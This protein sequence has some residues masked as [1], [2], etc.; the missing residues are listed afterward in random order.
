MF[1][2][3]LDNQLVSD[4]LNWADF[5]ETVE[6]DERLKLLWIKY[7]VKLTFDREGYNYIR[8]AYLNDGFCKLVELRVEYNCSGT[9]ENVLN[10]YIF[11]SDCKFN[12]TRCTVECDVFD[13]SYG[14]KI[15]NNKSL[16]TVISAPF[17][18]NGVSI[19]PAGKVDVQLFTPSTG[20]H[21]GAT[22]NVYVLHDVFRYLIDFM[23]DDTVN[24]ESDFLSNFVINGSIMGLA[25][26]KE[27]RLA[28]GTAPTISF[29]EL[30]E[31]LN[32]VYPIGMTVVFRNNIPTIKIERDDYFYGDTISIHVGNVQDLEQAFDNELLYSAVKLG[33]ETE[34][35]N[36]KNSQS[37]IPFLTFQEEEYIIQGN[38]NIDKVL[39]LSKKVF[40]DT[41]KIEEIFV[42]ATS[43]EKFDEKN[44][45][46]HHDSSMASPP[47]YLA[48][49]FASITTGAAPYF[50]NGNITN[51]KVAS[52]YNLAGS[53]A[54]YLGANN[55]GFQASKTDGTQVG[56]NVNDPAF[57]YPP[58][59]TTTDQKIGFNNDSTPPNYDAAGNYNTTTH[60][61]TA[62]VAGD[63]NFRTNL[64]IDVN[65]GFTAFANYRFR[66]VQEFRRFN[67]SNVLQQI[68][69]NNFPS[70]TTFFN[71]GPGIYQVEGDGLT[72]MNVGDYVEV[73]IYYDYEVINPTLSSS[74]RWDIRNFS[75]FLTISTTTG[76]G[77]YQTNNPDKYFVSK[78][79][80][81]RAIPQVAWNEVK[82]DLSRAI[83]FN[84]DEQDIN[85]FGWIR[86]IKRNL[87]TSETT[88]EL[89]SNFNN[90]NT[91]VD[92]GSGRG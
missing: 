29:Q 61:Y 37:P 4:A 88:I 16:K 71:D 51:D 90:A 11:I 41:N 5:E 65:K 21:S 8:N 48:T 53:I 17:S 36:T 56:V 13:S 84:A 44:F 54:N 39:D 27:L 92:A 15:Y 18:K 83:R 45:W 91:A 74:M 55:L 72:F 60:R 3:Y 47:T 62:S 77:I 25:S 22:R 82:K 1:K 43:S 20:V 57:S 75:K 2:F 70:A 58:M 66:V 14:A 79:M 42:T 6:R 69:R 12:L 26:G 7:D 80:F 73:W 30:F 24:F 63:F 76:G 64:I 81:E 32:K 85:R 31:E 35:D 78:F 38:C 28:N 59:Q 34:Y 86:K 50:Y 49:L 9:W 19:V 67:S 87:S 23:T 33:E 46:I 52:R 10:G 68:V 40:A 89:I